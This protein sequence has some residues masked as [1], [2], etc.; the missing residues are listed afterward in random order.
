MTEVRLGDPKV[1][2]VSAGQAAPQN[3]QSFGKSG[4]PFIRAGSLEFLCSGGSICELE[5]IEPSVAAEHRLKLFPKHTVVF[6][7]SGMSAKIGRVYRLAEPSYVVSHLAAITPK[8]KLDS[9]YLLYFLQANPPAKLIPNDA[10]P[11]I[12]LSEIENIIVQLPLLEEQ[13]RI[14]AILDK[15][16]AIRRKRQQSLKLIDDLVKSQFIEMFGDPV[17]NPMG[18]EVV[19]LE[20]LASLASGV[21]KGR[22]VTNQKLFKV[23]YMRVANVKDGYIDMSDI[24]YFEATEAEV[25][26]YRLENGDILMTEGGDPDKVGRGAIWIYDMEDCIHQNHIFRVRLD[27]QHVRPVYFAEYLK[28]QKAKQYFLRCAKQTTG[29]ASINMTQLKKL[30]VILPPLL[31]QNQFAAFVEQADKSKFTMQ[32]QLS[33]IEILSSSLKQKFFA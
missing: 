10:Y 26:Q 22:K 19:D 30:P 11:S 7:K 14:A 9:S 4:H 32:R 29:I 23:P 6:A 12:R 2:E 18:W 24:K 17:T 28:Q 20:R 25:S 33:E 3:M 13:R 1:A 21:T 16:D 31:L 5:H 27:A 15:V 8:E